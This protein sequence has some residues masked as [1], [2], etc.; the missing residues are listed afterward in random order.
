MGA[1]ARVQPATTSATLTVNP[2]PGYSGKRTIVVS[3]I[4]CA[5][6][7]Y[8]VVSVTI[9]GVTLGPVANTLTEWTPIINAPT[10]AVS[11]MKPAGCASVQLI[12][13]Q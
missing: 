11:T 4:P 9:N 5:D 3:Q 8:N 12:G 1:Y 6:S 7:Q 2:P 10:V 13:P